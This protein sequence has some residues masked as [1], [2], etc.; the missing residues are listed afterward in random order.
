M[1]KIKSFDYYRFCTINMNGMDVM[2]F[3][4]KT[5]R[6]RLIQTHSLSAQ[7][8]DFNEFGVVCY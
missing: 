1:K 6:N 2:I 3:I 5:Y 4:V 7:N 8:V